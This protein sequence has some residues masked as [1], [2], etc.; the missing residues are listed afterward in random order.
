MAKINLWGNLSTVCESCQS[1]KVQLLMETNAP[2][3][4]F[5]EVPESPYLPHA[6]P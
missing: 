1:L 4:V 2:D 3:L 6:A 5:S